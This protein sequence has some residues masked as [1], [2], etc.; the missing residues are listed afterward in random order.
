MRRSIAYHLLLSLL[1]AGGLAGCAVKFNFH[2]GGTVNPD[3]Q[4]LAI[5]VFINE[6]EI[7]VP[8]LAQEITQQMQDRFL[9][10]SRL[11]LTSGAADVELS[12]SITRYTVL[13]VAI[14]GADQAEQNRLTI[15]AR[16]KFENNVDP[17][18]SWEQTFTSFVDFDATADFGGQERDLIDEVLE[19]IT[20]DVFTKSIGKW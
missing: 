13:P 5:D 17:A 20:Q 7:V 2:G 12:G 18:D 19:Q 6:A 11:T 15:A 10:Q 9:N 14:T 4:T 16:V 8:Y 1:L 3:L